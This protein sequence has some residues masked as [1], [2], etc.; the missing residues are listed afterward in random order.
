MLESIREIV[1]WEKSIERYSPV[2]EELLSFTDVIICLKPEKMQLTISNISLTCLNIHNAL[3]VYFSVSFE[4][5]RISFSKRMQVYDFKIK[6]T[7]EYV[8]AKY[9]KSLEFISVEIVRHCL[10]QSP[11]FGSQSG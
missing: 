9:R 7:K 2:V 4:A 8:C 10:S 11:M 5:P 3:I 6:V 1:H